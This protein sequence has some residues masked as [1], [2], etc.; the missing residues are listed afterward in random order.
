LIEADVHLVPLSFPM[1]AP[2]STASTSL[3]T[4]YM[5]L[6]PCPP[7]PDVVDAMATAEVVSIFRIRRRSLFLGCSLPDAAH[8]DHP[9]LRRLPSTQL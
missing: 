1:P 9:L 7:A 4:R 2:P 6:P 8:L 3:R 5:R